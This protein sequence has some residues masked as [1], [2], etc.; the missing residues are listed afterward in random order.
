MRYL[1]IGL[2]SLTSQAD[3]VRALASL[4][5]TVD[6]EVV[7]TIVKK[8]SKYGIKPDLMVAIAVVESGVNHRVKRTNS[9]G[10]VDYGLFQ[11]N[12]VNRDFCKELDIFTVKGNA[13]CAAKL[14]AWHKRH[15]P[16]DSM[17]FCRYH[18]KTPSKKEIYCDKLKQV[19]SK[20]EWEMKILSLK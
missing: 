19:R 12:T 16:I 9:N 13:E 4:G 7:E 2:L 20:Y 17:W 14:L 11:I 1:L 18:S 6:R 3:T 15:K 8:A 10:T 5:Y